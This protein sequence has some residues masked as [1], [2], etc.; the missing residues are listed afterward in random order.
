MLSDHRD[1]AYTILKETETEP[2]KGEA[3]CRK[4]IAKDQHK[5]RVLPIKNTKRKPNYWWTRQIQDLRQQCVKS[6]RIITRTNQSNTIDQAAV[7]A[8]KVISFTTISRHVCELKMNSDD[9]E[10]PYSEVGEEQYFCQQIF[11]VISFT[12]ISR[13]VCELK[14]NSDDSESPYFE[15]GEEQS[16]NLRFI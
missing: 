13:H 7:Q 2:R 16:G 12:T 4:W 15:V 10:S 5:S 6:S 11:Q 1:I 8:T 9:S 3:T 14:M